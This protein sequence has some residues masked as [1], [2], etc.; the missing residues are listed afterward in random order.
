MGYMSPN[1]SDG[2]DSHS[3]F[4][5]MLKFFVH[6]GAGISLSLTSMDVAWDIMEILVAYSFMD[7]FWAWAVGGNTWASLPGMMCISANTRFCR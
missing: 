5:T 6:P 2:Y 4:C 3:G 1:A 7:H